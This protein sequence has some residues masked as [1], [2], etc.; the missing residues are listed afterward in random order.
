MQKLVIEEPYTFV[1]PARGTFWVHFFTPLLAPYLRAS[2]GIADVRLSGGD[3][4]QRSLSAGAGVLLT[5]NHVRLSD[6]MVL[7]TLRTQLGVPTFSMASWHLFK[8]DGFMGAANAWMMRNLG[9]FSVFREGN[10]RAALSCAIDALVTGERPLVLFPEGVVSMANDNPG[11]LL[12]GTAVIARSAA[13]RRAKL[14]DKEGRDRDGGVVIHPIGLRYEFL[15]DPA[16][17]AEKV[18]SRLEQRLGK[19][20][21]PAVP[22]F[23]R[24]H[25]LGDALLALREVEFTGAAKSGDVFD[26]AEDLIEDLLTPTEARLELDPGGTTVTRVKG[27]RTAILPLLTDPKATPAAKHKLRRELHAAFIAQQVHFCYPRGYLTEDAPPERLL[28][29]L[30][31]FDED[32]NDAAATVGRW[33]VR[34][35]IGPAIPVPPDRPRGTADPLLAAVD[36]GIRRQ[37]GVPV[38]E[39]PV[40]TVATRRRELV[41]A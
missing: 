16:P 26:R 9:A 23:V 3:L 22:Q 4:L 34:V 32:L 31:R 24:T 21:D 38:P 5:P 12:E 36:A 17:A 10:D 28:E 7:G 25:Q 33:R 2:Y 30:Q 15:D 35:D 20:P 39:D 37:I 14:A 1:P 19:W 18:L 29:T 41:A 13:K 27:V 11:P 6:P 8:Q 40:A